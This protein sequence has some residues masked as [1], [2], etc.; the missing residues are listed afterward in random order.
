M[1]TYLQDFWYRF[2]DAVLTP[3]RVVPIVTIGVGSAAS[4]VVALAAK[5]GLNVDQGLAVGLALPVVLGAVATA[6]NWQV[7]NQ[8]YEKLIDEAVRDKK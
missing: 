3:A 1:K 8:K 5:N 4:Y 7:G 2:R 6:L